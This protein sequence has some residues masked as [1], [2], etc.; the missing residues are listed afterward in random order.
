MGLA[1]C[2]PCAQFQHRDYI[3][4]D[5]NGKKV[6]YVRLKKCLYGYIKSALLFYRKLWSDLAS[7]G[8]KANPYDPC[9][10]NRMINGKQMTICW[11]VD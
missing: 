10:A 1:L 9:V 2:H 3:D 11:H 4:I 8:F 5:G 7:L 6:L